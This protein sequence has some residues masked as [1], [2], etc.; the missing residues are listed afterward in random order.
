M[1]PK[2][3]APGIEPSGQDVRA[4]EARH[5]A[6]PV[7]TAASHVEEPLQA[8]WAGRGVPDTVIDCNA[9]HIDELTKILQEKAKA[10]GVHSADIGLLYLDAGWGPGGDPSHSALQMGLLKA[11]EDLG[12]FVEFYPVK[13]RVHER[14]GVPVFCV[15]VSASDY[16]TIHIWKKSDAPSAEAAVA[17]HPDFKVFATG[18]SLGTDLPQSG[19]PTDAITW[20]RHSPEEQTAMLLG[21]VDRYGLPRERVANWRK[22]AENIAANGALGHGTELDHADLFDDMVTALDNPAYCLRLDLG[23]DALKVWRNPNRSTPS[24]AIKPVALALAGIKGLSDEIIAGITPESR[25]I[26]AKALREQAARFEP[27]P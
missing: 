22:Q 10:Y 2:S 21:I 27:Q 26:M 9:H 4:W 20:A 5:L 1:A 6:N 3:S 23:S 15:P 7:E 11:I 19:L 13:P 24:P 8:P 12:H 17:P 18:A 25:R 14:D 16:D